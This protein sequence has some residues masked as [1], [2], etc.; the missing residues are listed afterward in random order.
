MELANPAIKVTHKI[1]FLAEPRLCLVMIEKQG[2]Y[3]HPANARP[4]MHQ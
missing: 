3:R 1:G 4:M 2:S